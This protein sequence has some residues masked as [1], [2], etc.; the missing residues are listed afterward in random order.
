MKNKKNISMIGLII[1]ILLFIVGVGVTFAAYT[2]TRQG[3]YTSKQIVG[4]IYMHYAES[5]SLTLSNAMPS[6]TFDST[7]YFEFTVDGKNTTTNKTIWYDI[8]INRGESQTGTR[9]NDNL[10]KFKLVEVINNSETV[11]VDNQSYSDLSSGKRIYVST[12]PY[13]TGT[14]V[15]HTYRLYMRISERTTICGGDEDNCDYTLANWDQ[16]YASIKVNVTGDFTEKVDDNVELLWD[17]IVDNLGSEGIVAVKTDGTLYEGTGEIRDYRYSGSGNYCTYTDG[18]NDYNFQVE[19][20]TC[21]PKAYN[22]SGYR[23]LSSNDEALYGTG[24]YTKLNLKNN[25][26]PVDS[27]LRN[28]ISFNNE[29][30]RIV[31]I[32]DGNIKIV[33]DT[34]ITS[35]NSTYTNSESILYN[36][37]ILDSDYTNQGMSSIPKYRY[38]YWNNPIDRSNY[39]N[40]PTVG[41]YNYNDWTRSG[42]MYYLNEEN[43]YYGSLSNDAK[44]QI[45]N[46]TYHLGNV[47]INSSNYLIDGTANAVY[48]QERGTTMCDV[49]V[50]S[51]SQNANCNI[52]YGNQASWTGKIGLLYPSDYGYSANPSYWNSNIS[53]YYENDILGG[54]WILNTDANYSWFLSPASNDSYIS[55]Y[56]DMR[57]DV[58]RGSTYTI[59]CAL[60]P[61]LNL[62]SDTVI[63]AGEGSIESPFVITG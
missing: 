60:R 62:K 10:L 38:Y 45:I 26:T 7:K 16:V 56:W 19:G 1:S 20:T 32:V 2:Y 59:D 5:N 33:K 18:T 9:I 22:D 52:W 57:G 53:T 49:S 25:M 13:N 21:P 48:N 63:F 4:D 54:S 39:A 34:P 61:V 24:S 46:A 41:K 17:H 50:S 51:W 15:E 27:G 12:I 40:Q 8:V 43:G 6:S 29:L 36:L 28:Y 47:S 30:W 55:L 35:G 31:G 44:S 58:F 37:K 11:L 14:E 42:A 3:I 23:F